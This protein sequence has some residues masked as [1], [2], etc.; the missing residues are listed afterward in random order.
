MKSSL[1]WLP[2][3]SGLLVLVL[4]L[5]VAVLTVVNRGGSGT[6]PSQNLTTQASTAMASLSL[7][8]S[9]Q[10]YT[11]TPGLSYPVGIIVDSAGKSID[12]VDVVISFDP[13][14]VQ[15]TTP[16]VNPTTAFEQYP[17]NNVSN[18]AGKIRFSALTFTPK[19][20]NGIIA[21]FQIKP[22]AKGEVNLTFDFTPAATTDSNIAEHGT[23]KD[24][25]EKVVNGNY[26][27]N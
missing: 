18:P 13:Q 11:L 10:T 16:A 26:F 21:T 4:S 25:L 12:G 27:F 17:I 23:A 2:I 8:P 5:G 9:R 20:V 15:V 7:S 14:K 19:P 3:A 24:I 22:V 6:S 1:A